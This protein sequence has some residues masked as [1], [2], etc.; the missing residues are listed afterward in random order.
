MGEA[1]TCRLW[2]DRKCYQARLAEYGTVLQICRELVHGIGISAYSVKMELR[3]PIPFRITIAHY[4]VNVFYRGQVQQCFRCEQTG[5]LS[6]DCPLKASRGVPPSGI[7]GP[8]MA[9]PSDL[10]TQPPVDSDLVTQPPVDSLAPGSLVPPL[11]SGDPPVD[12]DPPAD[13][14]IDVDVVAVSSDGSSSTSTP[15]NAHT[16]KRQHKPDDSVDNPVKKD[17]PSSDVPDPSMYV[18]LERELLQLHLVGSNQ[19]PDDAEFTRSLR[20][21]FSPDTYR[22]Y[23]NTFR[24]RHPLVGKVRQHVLNILPDLTLLNWPSQCLDISG[25][26][27]LSPSCASPDLPYARYELIRTLL[28]CHRVYPDLGDAPVSCQGLWTSFLR[29]RLRH[30]MILTLLLILSVWATLVTI[31]RLL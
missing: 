27:L 1:D 8:H 11:A 18:T 29:I 19:T 22:I 30:I 23:C 9:Q 31:D 28:E 15:V 25:T 4:P 6:R 17:K 26:S 24:F 21:R 7:S 2:H 16:A 10:V 20:T 12:I 5:H 13:D 14:S 3:K